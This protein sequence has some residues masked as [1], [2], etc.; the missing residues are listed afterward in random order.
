MNDH[1]DV[2]EVS[3]CPYASRSCLCSVC[4]QPHGGSWNREGKQEVMSLGELPGIA[5]WL[6]AESSVPQSDPQITASIHTCF[7]LLL[8]KP[9]SW[10][11]WTWFASYLFIFP[12]FFVKGTHRATGDCWTPGRD[13]PQGEQCCMDYQYGHPSIATALS[14]KLHNVATSYM[15]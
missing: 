2:T 7:I 1:K 6:G 5:S 9:A 12:L 15:T 11:G 14:I 13:R 10:K 3:H 4:L 8:V